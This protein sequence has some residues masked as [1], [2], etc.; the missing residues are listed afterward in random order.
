M[1]QA[2]PVLEVEA[3]PTIV[4]PEKT[5]DQKIDEWFG[6]LTAP[7]VN[8]VFYPLATDIDPEKVAKMPENLTLPAPG[9]ADV[10]FYRPDEKSAWRRMSVTKGDSGLYCAELGMAEKPSNETKP[11]SGQWTPAKLKSFLVIFW[12]AAAGIILTLVFKFINIRAFGL[13]MRTV[14]GKYSQASDPG[15]VTHFQA[16]S[17]AVSGTVGLGNIAGVAIGIHSGGPGV[18]SRNAR[19]V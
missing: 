18:A 10:W 3:T 9:S 17:A 6:K 16:L 14:R 12:L 15:S 1:A 7:F 19:W 11:F 8:A 4:V 2:T 5:L 13:A